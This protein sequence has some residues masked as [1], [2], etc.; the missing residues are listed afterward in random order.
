MGPFTDIKLNLILIIS[1]EKLRMHKG[2]L[3]SA[4]MFLVFFSCH[5]LLL[6]YIVY[7]F[8][9]SLADDFPHLESMCWISH[10]SSGTTHIFAWNLAGHS[11]FFLRKICLIADELML[12][13]ILVGLNVCFF[14][15]LP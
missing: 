3:H 11:F 12:Y 8:K 14:V 9:P 4:R 5:F 13:G 2:T 7:N 15:H 6:S 1:D 10:T